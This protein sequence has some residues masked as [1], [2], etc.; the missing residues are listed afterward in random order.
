MKTFKLIAGIALMGIFSLTSCQSEV[1]EVQGDNPNTNTANSTTA[2]SIKRISMYDGSSDDALDGSSC[3]SILFPFSA[4]VNG[5]SLVNQLS[6]E[7][8]ITIL[9]Q[10]NNDTDT[11]VLQFPL[12]IRMSDYTEVTVNSQSEYNAIV[13]NCT[14]AENN[15]QAAISSL[16]IS[17]PITILTYDASL[18]QTGSTVITTERQLYTYMVNLSS[19]DY[20]SVKYPVTVTLADGTTATVNS[21]TELKSEITAA[22][23]IESKIDAAVENKAKLEKILVDGTFKVSSYIVAGV[24]SATSYYL[25][26]TIDFTNDWKVKSLEALTTVA[27]GTYSM[28]SDTDVYLQL[29]FT[30][31]TNFTVFNNTWKVISFTASTITLESKTNSAVKLVLKQI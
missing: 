6:Y 23:S 18:V 1:E 31:N 16:N 3:S 28:T 14:Q 9:G 22:L 2:N 24:E 7:Q 12:R 25:N 8:A 10:L 30:S 20:F 11:V 17:F 29:G 21:D 15:G 5:V 4:T 19:T 26:K 13:N 27:T